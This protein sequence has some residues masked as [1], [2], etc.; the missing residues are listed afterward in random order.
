MTTRLYG[1]PRRCP[2]DCGRTVRAG[3]L[4]C[5]ICW[6]RVPQ[7]LRPAVNAT[8]RIWNRTHDDDDWEAYMD[9]R[10][11]ALASIGAVP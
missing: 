1:E 11:A 5:G 2:A 4:L 9:A 7:H 10:A 3:H 6:A 8:W